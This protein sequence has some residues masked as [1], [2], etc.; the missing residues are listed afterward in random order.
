MGPDRMGDINVGILQTTV[1]ALS[2]N[3]D[4]CPGV[5]RKWCFRQFVTMQ[6]V[7]GGSSAKAAA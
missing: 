3:V 7:A 5:T 6:A 2:D 1:P 4:L